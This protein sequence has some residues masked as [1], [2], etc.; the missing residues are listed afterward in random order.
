MSFIKQLSWT[1]LLGLLACGVTAGGRDG[2]AVYKAECANCT[3]FVNSGYA[4]WG[5]N[6]GNVL[7][8]FGLPGE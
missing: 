6:P 1:M 2:E 8:G 5:A 7:L 3:V 4:I